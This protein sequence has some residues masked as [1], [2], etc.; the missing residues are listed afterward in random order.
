M[1]HGTGIL[2]QYQDIKNFSF[3][4]KKTITGFFN[5]IITSEI[6]NKLI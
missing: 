4:E 5:E 6:Q 3:T 1:V 2:I